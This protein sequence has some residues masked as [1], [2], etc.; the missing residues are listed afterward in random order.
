ML[1]LKDPAEPSV[2]YVTI[3]GEIEYVLDEDELPEWPAV[4][5]ALDGARTIGEVLDGL[6]HSLEAV[7]D[8]LADAIDLGIVVTAEAAP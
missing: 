4:L 8:E 7:H 3:D 5:R 6:G 2:W 1:L